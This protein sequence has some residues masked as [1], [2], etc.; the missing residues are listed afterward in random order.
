MVGHAGKHPAPSPTRNARGGTIINIITVLIGGTL[1][2]A[3]G[4]RLPKRLKAT[5]IAGMGG[6]GLLY[7]FV[8]VL[9]IF[10][11]GWLYSD[12]FR[13]IG[14]VVTAVVVEA[15]LISRLIRHTRRRRAS[16]R[17]AASDG[18]LL[19]TDRTVFYPLGGGQPGDSGRRAGSIGQKNLRPERL[20][21]AVEIVSREPRVQDRQ[22]VIDNAEQDLG[23]LV[24]P[25][26]LVGCRHQTL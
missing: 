15:V 3:F 12:S 9:S 4:A 26:Y 2:L 8:F 24:G 22:A 19:R 21:P 11:W 1:G 6:L 10:D 14:I 7:F 18:N 20:E 17:G 5:V 23:G 16:P 13:T 25:L